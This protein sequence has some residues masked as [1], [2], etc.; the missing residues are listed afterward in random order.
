[1][2]DDESQTVVRQSIQQVLQEQLERKKRREKE[3][4]SE[5]LV[6]KMK[7]G[8]DRE[9]GDTSTTSAA[10][11]TGRRVVKKAVGKGKRNGKVVRKSDF[12]S[13]FKYISLRLYEQVFK[14]SGL[15]T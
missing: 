3:K 14:I 6:K 12:V 4:D 5:P 8:R 13:K 7:N 10:T 9:I 15:S 1:M 11:I 2:S